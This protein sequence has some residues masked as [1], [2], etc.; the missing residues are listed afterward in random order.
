MARRLGLIVLGFGIVAAAFVIIWSR[1]QPTKD[2]S[3]RIKALEERLALLEKQGYRPQVIARMSDRGE[4][5]LVVPTPPAGPTAENQAGTT[6][7]AAPGKTVVLDEA[8]IQ[9]EYFGDLD[10][11]LATEARDASWSAP[12]EEKLRR[13]VRELTPRINVDKA[14][15][16]QTM[17]RVETTVPDVRE[18]AAALDKFIA[19]SLDILPEAV[20]SDG[21]RHGRHVV[22]FARPGS[23]FPPM[24]PPGSG[25]E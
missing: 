24:S 25:S 15:C 21:D 17:C 3:A 11:R 14:E 13:S 12:T 23:G 9:R 1:R 19:A 18:D 16:G 5:H 8:A 10:V 7:H 4:G 6:A 20:V 2:E 22:Y